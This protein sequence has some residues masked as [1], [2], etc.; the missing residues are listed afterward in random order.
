MNEFHFCPQCGSKRII[1]KSSFNW[2]C[3]DCNYTLY[4]NIASAVGLLL[5]CKG[6]LLTFTRV[7]E[8]AKGR[9]GLPGGFVNSGETLEEACM[10]EC[11]E[12]I[13]ITPPNFTYLASFPNV[14]PYKN[15]VYHTCDVFFSAEYDGTVDELLGAIKTV[16]G[17]AEN[18]I[19]P[20]IVELDTQKIAFDSMRRAVQ[21]LKDKMAL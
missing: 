8:P 7:N 3:P 19:M 4:N 11:Q 21:V 18:V 15:V 12:E 17:E 1:N 13:G 20:K 2:A 16:D 14:Y 9:L 10:R 5:T 6:H